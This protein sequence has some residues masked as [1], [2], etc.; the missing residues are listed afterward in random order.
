MRIYVEL[1]DLHQSM[2]IETD[3]FPKHKRDE[4]NTF[5]INMLK[6]F[7]TVRKKNALK[8]MKEEQKIFNKE[9]KEL[10]KELK[11]AKN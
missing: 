1:Q 6:E 8:R 7:D 11:D 3:D 5:F 10:E 2:L 9:I 4:F